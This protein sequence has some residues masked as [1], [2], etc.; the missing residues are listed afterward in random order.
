MV[1]GRVSAWK[2]ELAKDII[3]LVL[4]CRKKRDN[5]DTQKEEEE[6]VSEVL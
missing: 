1:G 4:R 3:L 2:L 5:A 6:E